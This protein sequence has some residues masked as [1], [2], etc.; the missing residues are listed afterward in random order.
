MAARQAPRG[1][2]AAGRQLYR[3]IT[4]AYDL[5][6][7]E[8]AVLA[9]A[10]RVADRIADLDAVV[11]AE[12]VMFTDARRGTVPHPAL[13]ESRQQRLALARLMTAMRLPDADDVR[14]QRRGIRGVYSL[15]ANRGA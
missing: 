13:V 14:P 4:D 15:D 3:S 2:G 11:D 5:E 1:T 10:A 8:L 12:G 6:P 9:S 7:H